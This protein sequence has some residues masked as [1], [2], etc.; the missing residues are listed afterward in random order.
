MA[1]SDIDVE[2]GYIVPHTVIGLPDHRALGT[3]IGAAS[4]TTGPGGADRVPPAHASTGGCSPVYPRAS[5]EHEEGAIAT[6]TPRRG[7]LEDWSDAFEAGRRRM[8]E[9]AGGLSGEQLNFR[10]APR[11]WSLGQCL[12]HL[13]VSM[14]IYLDPLEPV[15][16]RA[17]SA[18]RTGDEPYG[19]GTFMGRFLVRA[20]KKAGKRYPAPPSFRPSRSELDP[21]D[22]RAGFEEQIGRMLAAVQRCHGLALGEIRM[23]W[24]AFPL[25]RLSLAQAFELQALHLHRHLDQAERVTRDPGFPTP[26]RA[27]PDQSP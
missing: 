27:A 7:M 2:S 12:D 19:R 1:T 18:G 10:P 13:R 3:M 8:H 4:A 24:P 22:V 23:P 14:R 16:A 17:R 11:R 6:E 20:L 15:V 9:L 25:V 5:T 26:S 21:D